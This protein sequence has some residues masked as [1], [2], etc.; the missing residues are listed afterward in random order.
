MAGMKISNFGVIMGFLEICF[1]VG[2]VIG[3]PA[4]GFIFDQTGSYL[5]PFSAVIAGLIAISAVCLF[6]F[7]KENRAAR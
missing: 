3:P 7:P 6:A 2:G 4:A 5:V 1:G